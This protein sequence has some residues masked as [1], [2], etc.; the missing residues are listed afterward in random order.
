MVWWTLLGLV[1][2]KRV[3]RTRGEKMEF[4]MPEVVELVSVATD[5]INY[6]PETCSTTWGACC[7]KE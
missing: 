1:V 7:Y 4:E 3:K 2:I 5:D 6:G